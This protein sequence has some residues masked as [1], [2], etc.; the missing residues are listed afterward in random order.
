MGD[1]CSGKRVGWET[2]SAGI[3]FRW[4]VDRTMAG[5]EHKGRMAG[6]VGTE[7]MGGN[8]R[9]RAGDKGCGSIALIG[10][11]HKASG[12]IQRIGRDIGYG[13]KRQERSQRSI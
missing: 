4:E 7:G 13:N 8:I 2:I 6:E 12:G 5:W 9:D 10:R 3:S 1:K 11:A